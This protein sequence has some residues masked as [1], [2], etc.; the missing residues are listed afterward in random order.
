MEPLSRLTSKGQFFP[1]GVSG[2]LSLA[3]WPVAKVWMLVS[4]FGEVWEP[5]SSEAFTDILGL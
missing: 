1:G 5:F 2:H 4:R 3:N